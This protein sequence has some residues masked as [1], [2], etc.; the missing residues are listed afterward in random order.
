MTRS[1][2][3]ARALLDILLPAA[4][5]EFAVGDLEEA[6][7]SLAARAGT[8][9]ARRWYWTQTCHLLARRAW[10]RP[11][12]RHLRKTPSGDPPMRLVLSDLRHQL[13][14]LRAQPGF[15]ITVVGTLAL[16]IGLSTAMFSAVSSV[17][18][19]PLPYREPDRLVAVWDGVIDSTRSCRPPTSS[20]CGLATAPS[21]A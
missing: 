1:P 3:L 13:R 2:H 12:T 17:L 10:R 11:P 21:R 5:R 8:Q 20:I 14:L 18:L 6:F 19:R 7:G 9:A 15:T 4:D 16:G